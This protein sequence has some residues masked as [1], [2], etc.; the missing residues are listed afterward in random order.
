MPADTPSRLEEDARGE[1]PRRRRR[2]WPWIAL[3]SIIAAP[4]LLFAAWAAITLNYTYSD[5]LRTGYVLKFSQKGW[6]CK[7]WE[8]ELSM[9]TVPGVAPEKWT[10][11]VR[12]DAVAQRIQQIQNA[13]QQVTL[14]Y[15]EHRG[16][17][18]SCFGETDY[19]IIQA[20][21]VAGYPTGGAAGYPPA[22]APPLPPGTVPGAAPGATPGALPPGSAPPAPT[23][24]R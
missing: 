2:A 14:H 11:S 4:A 21:P 1:P 15:E 19:F 6:L 22:P 7:T 9:A 10:F 16:V 17:P 24:R 12:D 18:S 3:L 8:G 20:N 5:G 23:G 13:G